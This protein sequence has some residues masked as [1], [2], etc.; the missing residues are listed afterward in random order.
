[1]LNSAFL[2]TISSCDM[3]I[4]LPPSS[5]WFFQHLKCA[6]WR[7]G[8]RRTLEERTLERGNM[9]I[10]D[11]LLLRQRMVS[12][13][14]SKK[15][16]KFH[17]S[18]RMFRGHLAREKRIPFRYEK[19]CTLVCDHISS[20]KMNRCIPATSVLKGVVGTKPT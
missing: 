16:K 10:C 12:N 5:S 2:H 14:F 7:Q 1:M 11:S 13:H 20:I 18:V 17:F 4:I 6:L 3:E 8:E 19:E 15:K 9:C